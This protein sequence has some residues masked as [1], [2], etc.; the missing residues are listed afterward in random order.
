MVGV[1]SFYEIT[2][3]MRSYVC[4]TFRLLTKIMRCVCVIEER[5]V[6]SFVVAEQNKSL[7][8]LLEGIT[9]FSEM[10]WWDGTRFLVLLA[11]FIVL[12]ALQY[13][14]ELIF[15]N[16]FC[17]HTCSISVYY[18]FTYMDMINFSFGFC[19][20]KGQFSSDYFFSY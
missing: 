17:A 15:L 12:N 14:I 20:P 3:R 10:V 5:K 9:T 19:K 16:I 18:M 2:L 11:N 8:N 4:V 6:R 7:V 13:F 1:S